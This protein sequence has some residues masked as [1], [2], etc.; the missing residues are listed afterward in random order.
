MGGRHNIFEDQITLHL[1]F[2]QKINLSA[3]E[4]DMINLSI[5]FCGYIA[6]PAVVVTF[7]AKPYLQ[8]VHL[9]YELCVHL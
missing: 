1:C 7:Y 2:K 6:Q 8:T 5:Q 3:G 9:Y 4:K